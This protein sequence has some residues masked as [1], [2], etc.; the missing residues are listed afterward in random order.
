M[1]HITIQI[2]HIYIIQTH[3]NAIQLLVKAKQVIIVKE[4]DQA[5]KLIQIHYIVITMI[6]ILMIPVIM[7]EGDYSLT[8]KITTLHLQHTMV[9]FNF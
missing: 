1:M 3:G 9:V 2:K 8:L 4:M 5:D 6:T 7:V